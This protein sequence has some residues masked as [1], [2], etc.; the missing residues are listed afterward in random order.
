MLVYTRIC[1]ESPSIKPTF[2]WK[3]MAG[4]MQLL[5]VRNQQKWQ[6]S[7]EHG[8]TQGHITHLQRF[9]ERRNHEIY[10]TLIINRLVKRNK[11]IVLS[12]GSWYRAPKF[13]EKKPRGQKAV[14]FILQ[15]LYSFEWCFNSWENNAV[16]AS[17]PHTHTTYFYINFNI[18]HRSLFIIKIKTSFAFKLICLGWRLYLA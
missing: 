12:F 8:F 3:W 1:H 16:I 7:V 13:T 18:L 2:K 4:N 14:F 15:K 17:V 11:T 9:C 5:C 10:F 6:N